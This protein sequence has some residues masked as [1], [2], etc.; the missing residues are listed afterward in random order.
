[1]EDENEFVNFSISNQNILGAEENMF[2]WHFWRWALVQ[3]TSLNI[4]YYYNFSSFC[5]YMCQKMAG[6]CSSTCTFA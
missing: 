3:H 5:L 2:C 1:M 6:L 4:D